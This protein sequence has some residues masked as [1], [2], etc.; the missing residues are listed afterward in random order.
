MATT[1]SYGE[2]VIFDLSRNQNPLIDWYEILKLCVWQMAGSQTKINY[3]SIKEA[4][5]FRSAGPILKLK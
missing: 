5:L 1:L 3:Y 2:T 4:M